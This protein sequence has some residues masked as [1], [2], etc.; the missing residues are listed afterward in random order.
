M[1]VLCSIAHEDRWE[2]FSWR[3]LAILNPIIR[4]LLTCG[5]LRSVAASLEVV[6]MPLG[7]VL[8]ESGDAQ[9]QVAFAI[10]SLLYVMQGGGSVEIAVVGYRASSACSSL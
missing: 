5:E 8:Y 1:L 3:D 9:T 10:V 2:V 4:S 6:D 7:Q